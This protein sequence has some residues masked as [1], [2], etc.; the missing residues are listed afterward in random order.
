MFYAPCIIVEWVTGKT[1]PTEKFG[2]LNRQKICVS[3]F[4]SAERSPCKNV[5]TETEY[6]HWP[7]WKNWKMAT[8]SLILIAWK[9]FKLLTPPKVWVSGF[10]SVDGN[11]ISP[12]AIMKKLKNGYHFVNIDRMEKFQTTDDPPKVWVSSFLCV[13]GNGIL[14]SAIIKKLKNGCQTLGGR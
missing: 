8:I 5:S 12:S 1:E 11:G 2:K 3:R 14:P 10:P 6:H 4:P 9:N 13:D 7:L